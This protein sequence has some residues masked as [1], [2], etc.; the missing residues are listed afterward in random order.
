M[1]LLLSAPAVEV[2]LHASFFF[3]LQTTLSRGLGFVAIETLATQALKNCNFKILALIMQQ[4]Q[5][6]LLIQPWR[7]K[8][9]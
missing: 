8:K 4:A 3:P 5:R 2:T 1:K 6:G 9:S 7:L